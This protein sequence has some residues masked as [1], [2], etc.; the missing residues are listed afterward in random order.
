VWVVR[1]ECFRVIIRMIEINIQGCFKPD[2]VLKVAE[3]PDRVGSISSEAVL[4]RR[5][6][7]DVLEGGAM[8]LGS[9]LFLNSVTMLQIV[10]KRSEI[11]RDSQRAEDST[12]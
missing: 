11:L 4:P 2:A 6:G 7:K 10:G 3:G 5:E 8:A 1:G 9:G 12:R